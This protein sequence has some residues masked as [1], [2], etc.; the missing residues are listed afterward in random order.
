MLFSIKTGFWSTNYPEIC[1]LKK[2]FFGVNNLLKKLSLMLLVHINVQLHVFMEYVKYKYMCFVKN[3]I[4]GCYVIWKSWIKGVYNVFSQ[5]SW[6][7]KLSEILPGKAW[8]LFLIEILVHYFRVAMPP[9]SLLKILQI[10]ENL[11]SSKGFKK[12]CFV[13]RQISVLP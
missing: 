2:W 11:N 7:M 6:K 10:S 5:K 13:R 9:Q 8:F 4:Q 3:C 1:H 12:P